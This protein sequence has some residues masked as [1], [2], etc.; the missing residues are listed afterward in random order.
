M[1]KVKF[2]FQRNK[3]FNDEA[4]ETDDNHSILRMGIDIGRQIFSPSPDNK[5][6]IHLSDKIISHGVKLI[7]VLSLI[8]VTFIVLELLVYSNA[9][10]DRSQF[11]SLFPFF[12]LTFITIFFWVKE[13]PDKLSITIIIFL[14]VFGYYLLLPVLTNN[15]RNIFDPMFFHLPLYFIAICGI[16]FVGK[17]HI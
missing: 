11:H 7:G 8:A 13:K 5:P 10:V 15:L 16:A 3:A 6:T 17:E 14:A 2:L 12:Y 4:P 1:K 9:L